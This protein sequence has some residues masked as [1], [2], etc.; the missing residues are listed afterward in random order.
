MIEPRRALL[1]L[2]AAGDA[3]QALHEYRSPEELASALITVSDA[4]EQSLRHALRT[5]PDAPDELRLAALSAEHLPFDR[6]LDTLRERAVL[7]LELAGWI[8]ELRAAAAR[9]PVGDVHAADADRAHKVVA[10]LRQELSA[11]SRTSADVEPARSGPDPEAT[12]PPAA[13]PPAARRRWPILLGLF[14]VLVALVF[15]TLLLLRPESAFNRGIEAFRQRRMGVAE[16]SFLQAVADDSTNVTARLYLARI[17]REQR[18]YADA[19]DQ[20][21]IAVALAPRDPDVRRELGGLFFDLHRYRD[22]AAQYQRALDIAPGQELN[23]IGLISALR[24]A[25]DPRA[26]DVLGRAPADVRARFGT[27]TEPPTDTGTKP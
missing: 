14:A 25:G 24:A 21:R 9:A 10:R 17:A 8:H 2:D 4:V 27:G 19:A 16:Q 6:V 23:W 20:L 13:G 22:A 5:D 3:I 1:P 7:S 18:R 15:A 26:R 12:E 11:H